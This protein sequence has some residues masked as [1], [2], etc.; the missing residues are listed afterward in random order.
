MHKR[1][2]SVLGSIN[3]CKEP[4]S[5]KKELWKKFDL[6]SKVQMLYDIVVKKGLQKDVAK[7][8]GRSQSYVSA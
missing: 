6:N 2:P 7:K 5:T 8:Y 4:H 1:P 3:I